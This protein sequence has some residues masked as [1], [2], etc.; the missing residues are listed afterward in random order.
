M[1]KREVVH[2]SEADIIVPAGEQIK[3][4]EENF[5]NFKKLEGELVNL[6]HRG[7]QLQKEINNL[8]KPY[9][10]KAKKLEIRIQNKHMA[11][12][13]SLLEKYKLEGVINHLGG[14]VP[15]T[16]QIP[17]PDDIPEENPLFVD[18]E[19]ADPMN[20]LHDM[21][22]PP[23]VAEALKNMTPEMVEQMANDIISSEQEEQRIENENSKSE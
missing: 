6:Q 16:M 23:E 14:T 10:V 3:Q 9:Q 13:R 5:L 12:Q 11:I 19:N 1:T 7:E 22:M 17:L 15:E 8:V 18:A 4:Y 20:G 2:T 21:E